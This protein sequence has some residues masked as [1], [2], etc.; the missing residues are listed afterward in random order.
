MQI[1][2]ATAGDAAEWAYREARPYH[3]LHL[4]KCAGLLATGANSALTIAGAVSRNLGCIGWQ[5]RSSSTV[6]Q[7]QTFPT[8]AVQ[9]LVS[10]RDGVRIAVADSGPMDADH[11]IVLLHGLCLSRQSWSTP[12]YLLSES[13]SDGVRIISYDHRGHGRSQRAPTA[14]YHVDQL[15]DDLADIL[16][17]LRIDSPLTLAG[18]SLGG[19]TA[20]TY[21]ARPARLQPVQP[22]GLVLVATAAGQLVERGMGR[23][24]ATPAPRLLG[25]LAARA[26]AAAVEHSLRPMAWTACELLVRCRG[27]GSA[28]REALCGMCAAALASTALSTAAGFLPQLRRFDQTGALSAIRARTTVLSGGADLLTPVA[29]AR[30]LVAGIRGAAHHHYPHAGHMMLQDVPRAVAD[31]IADVVHMTLSPRGGPVSA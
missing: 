8:Q 24:L 6:R 4:R 7:P 23:L 22:H 17:E 29:H 9:R 31:A 5:T 25:A 18:H 16:E 19:M 21:S 1:Q 27:C 30:Q 20:L 2:C 14:T 28:E 13:L 15:A 12:A 26:P 3:G 11:T 10:A